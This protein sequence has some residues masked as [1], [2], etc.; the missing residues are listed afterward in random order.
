MAALQIDLLGGTAVRVAGVDVAFPT[1][2]SLLLLACLAMTPGR[3]WPRG[4]L[5]NLLWG[6]RAE[7]QA[8]S[9]LRQE[10]YNLRRSLAAV[11][12]SPLRVASDV[13]A[14]EP[15]AV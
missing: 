10:L 11:Q 5:M 3:P 2:K 12:P 9:S 13:V 1:R 14:L 7:S 4:K 6:D 15:D 8:R